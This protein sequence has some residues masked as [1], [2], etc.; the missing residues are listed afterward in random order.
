MIG[1]NTYL[2]GKAI[3]VTFFETMQYAQCL[4]FNVTIPLLC[5]GQAFTYKCDWPQD[6]VVSSCIF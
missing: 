2:P 1:Y 4:S 3:M 6:G 5:T